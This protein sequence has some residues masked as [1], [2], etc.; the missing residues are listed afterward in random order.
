MIVC[1]AEKPSV[2]REIA[3]VLGANT[4][5]KGY[6]EGNGYQVTWTFGHLCT[7]KEPQ[8][9]TDNWK[10]WSLGSLPMIPPRF[11][12]KLIEDAG[13]EE[14]FHIIEGLMRQAEKVINCGDAGQEGELIQRWVMQKAGC[15]CPVYRL[16]VSSLTEEAIREGF[17]QL[18]EQ[19]AYTK[20]YEAGLSRAIGD[21]LL[22]MNA[23]RLY[24]L[25]YGS[26]R[27]V[28]SIG[29]VQTPTLALIVNRQAE[30]DHF[31]PEPFWELKTIY[32]GVTFS[33]T[34]GK[35]AT[36][37]EG[38]AFL[39][40]V[41][42]ADFEVTA[43]GEKK[44]KEFAP[45]LF[46]LTSL[47]VE[48][49]KKFSFSADDT[50]KLIQSLYEK[51]V[52]TY[53][54]VDTTFLS[55]DLYPKV[56][57]ALKGLVDYTELTAPLLQ[58]NKLPKSKRVFDNSKV[59]DHHAI[60]P[61]GVPA[62]GLSNAEQKVYDLV[63]RRFI[64]AFYPDCEISTTTVQGKVGKVE[65]KVSGKQILKPGWRIVF[66][67]D[68]K[69]PDNDTPEEN[70]GVLPHFDKGESGPHQPLLKEGSTQPPKPYTEATLLRAM[71]T[72]GK[73]VEN[74]ELRDALKENG[75]GRPSTRAAIIETLFKRHYIRKERKNLY[76]TATG[77]ELIAT[78]H[79]ELLKSAE[80]TGLW[81]KKL[82]QIERG[83]YEARTFLDELKQ[84]AHQVVYNVLSDQSGRTITIEQPATEPA[85][86]ER[87]PRSKSTSETG[88]KPQA[89]PK[90]TKK[91]E[92]T[93]SPTTDNSVPHCP[94]CGKGTLLRGKSAYGCSEYKNGCTFRLDY[95]TY[96]NSLTDQQLIELIGKWTNQ[97]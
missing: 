75:I 91:A 53:P 33:S 25:R 65:F 58:L 30:I 19:S 35:F 96:G 84:L 18:K 11:S 41:R 61:T 39:D 29:R 46:D 55:D 12:I 67:A 83:T 92:A 2:A 5:H 74:D 27:Q 26:N 70:N 97:A 80:L 95:T 85:K 44:G 86:K 45:R 4:S 57:Q 42:Q 89:K 59:T 7:L 6:M 24:T 82:R 1:I 88:E 20:L 79:D 16:W 94:L 36:K 51:K 64:A 77:V 62:R 81:E 3:K 47:Q 38:E 15:Q 50:L 40:I 90:R 72:A 31:K 48:C 60:I 37:E 66:G 8:D 93:A 73:L 10:R 63:A 21:W 17:N 23:T 56:P 49:N 13:G 9:Y 71:E 22:G 52:T 68:Q 69:D 54:R 14:Q 78:I 32:R 43:I 28:L 34:K 76:P 87:K